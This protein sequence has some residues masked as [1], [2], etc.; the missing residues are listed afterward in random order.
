ML[1]SYKRANN[2][3]YWSLINKRNEII[4]NLYPSD[5]VYTNNELVSWIDSVID[6]AQIL[7]EN[8][9]MNE[10]IEFSNKMDDANEVTY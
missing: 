4:Q 7:N 9:F 5:K 6:R 2:F 3:F 10:I 8:S 1:D